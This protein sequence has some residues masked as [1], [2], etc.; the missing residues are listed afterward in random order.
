MECKVAV[1]NRLTNG[2][3]AQAAEFA[4]QTNRFAPERKNVLLKNLTLASGRQ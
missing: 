1:K 2:S 3:F 4:A